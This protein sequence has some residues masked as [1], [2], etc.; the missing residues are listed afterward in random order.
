VRREGVTEAALK[1]QQAGLTRFPSM[2]RILIA[3]DDPLIR[4]NCRPLLEPEPAIDEIGEAAT[5]NE[6]LDHLRLSKWQL[7][8]LAIRMP[9]RSGHDILRHIVSGIPRCACS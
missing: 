4:K 8:L 9:D 3:N 2:S 6:T 7:V 1:L 5:G